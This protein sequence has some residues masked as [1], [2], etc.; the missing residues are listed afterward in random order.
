[1]GH[2]VQ[3]HRACGGG[4]VFSGFSKIKRGRPFFRCTK[5]GDE[6]SY[7]ATG[8]EWAALVPAKYLHLVGVPTAWTVAPRGAEYPDDDLSGP[9]GVGT[10]AEETEFALDQVRAPREKR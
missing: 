6:W 2:R 7:G 3:V 9:L 4:V 10:L 5:C 1:M 8:G